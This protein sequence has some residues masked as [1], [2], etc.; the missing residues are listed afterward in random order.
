MFAARAHYKE[1]YKFTK[2]EFTRLS[3]WFIG[4]GIMQVFSD[5]AHPEQNGRDER[6]HRDLK[7]ACAL[8]SA[9]D[10]KSQQRKLNSFV[11][12][13]N[14][15]RPHEA[16]DMETPA[17]VHQQSKKIFPERIRNYDYP[18]QM[19][20]MSVCYNG[21]VRWKSYYWVYLS[22]GLIGRYDGAEELGNGIWKVYYRKVFLGYFNE[23]DIREKEKSI[24]LSTN[25]V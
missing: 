23:N 17:K 14:Q 7:A 21:S 2:T 16:L 6:M 18:S 5:S 3:H 13:Y 12:E 22:R 4:L 9:Y 1:D 10:M 24:R 20:V 11:K 19:K 25:L 8:P 15:V